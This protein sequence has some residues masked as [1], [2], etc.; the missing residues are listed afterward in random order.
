MSRVDFSPLLADDPVIA[1]L[2]ADHAREYPPIIDALLGGGVRAIELT[3]STAG[4]LAQISSLVDEFGDAVIGLGTV[5]S[6]EQAET[7]IENGAKFIVTPTVELD[8]I[9]IACD[10]GVPVFG[11]GLTPTELYRCWDAGASAVKLF[12][13]SVVGPRYIADVGGP[14]PEMKI[15]PSGGVGLDDVGAWIAAGAPAVSVG[16]PLLGDAFSGGDLVALSARARRFRTVAG[17]ALARR[18]AVP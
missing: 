15:V 13:A 3:L 6:G 9:R 12:P 5:T 2:R 8:V 16:G 10:A 4:V 17:D 1:V 11:G 7:A 14:F 18:K